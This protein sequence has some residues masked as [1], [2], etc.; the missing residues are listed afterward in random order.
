[1]LFLTLEK[2][3][4]STDSSL[5]LSL[6]PTPQP[7][8]RRVREAEEGG[9]GALFSLDAVPPPIRDRSGPPARCVCHHGAGPLGQQRHSQPPI[10]M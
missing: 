4:Q 1:M 5:G 8:R 2:D 10:R 7:Q 9:T 6:F 3:E